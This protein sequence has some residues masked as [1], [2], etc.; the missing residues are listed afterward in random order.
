MLEYVRATHR[1]FFVNVVAAIFSSLAS[2]AA[3]W[4]LLSLRYWKNYTIAIC[5]LQAL[6]FFIY[7]TIPES[8]RWIAS[9]GH[10]D[11]AKIVLVRIA[12]YNKTELK[13]EIIDCLQK[14][15]HVDII[16]LG[17]Y[18]SLFGLLKSKKVKGRMIKLISKTYV[19][20]F[21]KVNFLMIL[22]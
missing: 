2:G 18:K 20:I 15:A 8:Y 21:V 4:L 9:T 1:T 14:Y 10:V 19:N 11:R 22:L 3:P 13:Q 16:A 5:V 6:A 17:N 7:L 12:T